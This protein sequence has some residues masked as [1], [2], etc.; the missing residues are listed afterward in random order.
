MGPVKNMKSIKVELPPRLREQVEALV[1]AGWF[2]KEQDLIC[3][4]VR[5]FVES[6]PPD[7]MTQA[8]WED[9][10]WGLRGQA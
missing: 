6:H 5:R 1:R 4:A 9:V 7:A 3:E 8:V 2:T 10:D